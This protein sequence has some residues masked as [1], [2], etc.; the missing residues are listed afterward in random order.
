[1]QKENE[2]YSVI[3]LRIYGMDYC[4]KDY[5]GRTPEELVMAW[6]KDQTLQAF[7]GK[8]SR[9]IDGGS[10]AWYEQ[11]LT[12]ETDILKME[13][14]E[15]KWMEEYEGKA[16]GYREKLL[17]TAIVD[18][19]RNEFEVCYRDKKRI[20]LPLAEILAKFTSSPPLGEPDGLEKLAFGGLKSEQDRPVR[21]FIDMDGVLAKFNQVDT[22]ETLYEPGY[23]LNLAPQENVLEAVKLLVKDP[24]VEV[25]ILSSVLPDSRYALAEK[26]AWLNRF[27]PEIDKEHRI[28]PPCGGEKK[29]YIPYGIRET[30]CLLDDYTQNLSNW[31]P[32]A[33]GIKLL[34][35]I[36][37]TKGTWQGAKV[38]HELDGEE[39]Y[40][41][42][43]ACVPTP[44]TEERKGWSR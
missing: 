39:L 30:D 21:A 4:Y 10:F 19:D 3:C 22:L 16:S 11:L 33:K 13:E 35:G 44:P 15:Q 36:N 25:F 40:Q 24:H 12:E 27:L 41:R 2:K 34:N 8:E 14:G 20:T 23:F 28:F 5:S 31:E 32:P 26:N 38:S 7:A 37:H 1:M 6:E 9:Q 29:N 42:I 18:V 43:I 17:F